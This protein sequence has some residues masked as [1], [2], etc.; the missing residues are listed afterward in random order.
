MDED[1]EDSRE[2]LGAVEAERGWS[3]SNKVHGAKQKAGCRVK[4]KDIEMNDQLFAE[5]M[6]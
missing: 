5:K 4:V 3:R 1:R 6:M 2:E